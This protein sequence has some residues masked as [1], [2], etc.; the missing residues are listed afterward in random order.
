MRNDNTRSIRQNVVA[1]YT[2]S[3]T[4]E[5]QNVC[6]SI[7]PHNF[8]LLCIPRFFFI[9]IFFFSRS[10]VFRSVVRSL[11]CVELQARFVV[12]FSRVIVCSVFFLLLFSLS[13]SVLS[14]WISFEFKQRTR[15]SNILGV[16]VCAAQRSKSDTHSLFRSTIYMYIYGF[17]CVLYILLVLLLFM[18]M[19]TIFSH[20][21]CRWWILRQVFVSIR[22]NSTPNTRKTLWCD[23]DVRMNWYW[24]VVF[25]CTVKKSPTP[26]DDTPSVWCR[27]FTLGS[28]SLSFFFFILFFSRFSLCFV[29]SLLHTQILFRW[30]RVCTWAVTKLWKI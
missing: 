18:L 5:K 1:K 30:D 10:L 13:H 8:L 7:S 15:V 3:R 12:Y 28:Q 24:R 11:F 22:Y 27:Y 23:N 6:L 9:I 19:K 2:T 21:I 14:F 16:Y 25:L 17:V 26:R 29:C 20:S 4:N